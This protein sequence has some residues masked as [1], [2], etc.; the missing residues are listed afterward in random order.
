MHIEDHMNDL[1][2]YA[3]WAP[4]SYDHKGLGCEEQQDW[5]VSTIETNRDADV[6]QESNWEVQLRELEAL[7]ESAADD[8]SVE[9]FS[10]WGPGWLRIVLVRPGS[11]AHRLVTELS[12]AVADYPVLDDEDFSERET[13]AANQHWA[14]MSQ[15][16]RLEY[17]ADNASEFHFKSFADMLACSRGKWFGGYPGE[18]LA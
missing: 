12:L 4:T 16:E 7:G 10:H 11:A 18:L 2:L 8:W 17:M 6:L 9:S 3:D 15:D 1:P 14:C 13:E 5:H